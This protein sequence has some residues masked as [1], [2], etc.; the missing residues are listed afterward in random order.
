MNKLEGAQKT[1]MEVAKS[2]MAATS[3]VLMPLN[4]SG[5][6]VVVKIVQ[7]FDY[8]GFIDV[9]KPSNIDSVF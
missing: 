6:I 7:I 1:S 8:I 4:T 2:T 5:G 9:E 3:A